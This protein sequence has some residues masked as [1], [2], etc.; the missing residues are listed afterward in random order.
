MNPADKQ[1]VKDEK[2]AEKEYQTFL[3]SD[4]SEL[5]KAEKV[6]EEKQKA[7]TTANENAVKA[8]QDLMSAQQEVERL[9]ASK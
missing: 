1:V 9:K 4:T 2:A 3:K 7:L 6:C 8:H 5:A